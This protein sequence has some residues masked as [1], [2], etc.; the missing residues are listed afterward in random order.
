MKEERKE[1]IPSDQISLEKLAA[2]KGG[3]SLKTCSGG[4]AINAN[5]YRLTVD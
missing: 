2:C 5:S 3:V 1:R 4:E